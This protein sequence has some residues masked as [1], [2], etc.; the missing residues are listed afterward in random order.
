MGMSGD[1]PS[2]K[3]HGLLGDP[4]RADSLGFLLDQLGKGR[5]TPAPASGDLPQVIRAGVAG[6]G[7]STATNGVGNE[8]VEVHRR[9]SSHRLDIP[10]STLL[11]APQIRPVYAPLMQTII[12]IRRTNLARLAAEEGSQ[13]ALARKV[14]KDRNQINQWLGKGQARDM[15]NAT[16]R[17]FEDKCMKPR[18]WMD[19]L[20]QPVGIGVPIV[21]SALQVVQIVGSPFMA[22]HRNLAEQS[23]FADALSVAIAALLDPATPESERPRRAY[24]A[25]TYFMEQLKGEWGERDANG[26]DG[27][28]DSESAGGEAGERQRG[29]VLGQRLR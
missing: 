8:V 29:K 4:G 28:G 13:A 2:T 11:D 14:D 9:T 19:N 23:W 15:D 6:V 21:R 20:S 25:A 12:E 5:A 22:D 26:A 17:M 18:G 27:G 3:D 24:E 7:Q 1:A 10:S 16:A